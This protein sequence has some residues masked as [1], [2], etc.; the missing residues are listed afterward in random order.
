MRHVATFS[1]L[2][3]SA[4]A[5]HLPTVRTRRVCITR[6]RPAIARLGEPHGN[7]DLLRELDATKPG[8]N[9]LLRELDAT[10]PTLSYGGW[11]QDAAEV[12]DGLVRCGP[13]VASRMLAKMRRKQR[14]H[15]GDR[16]DVA[17][18]VLDEVK[19]GLAY[20]GWE[21]DVDRVERDWIGGWGTNI[22]EVR[23]TMRR[24]QQLHEGERSDVVLQVL[25]D[26]KQGL[27]YE[28]WEE[29]VRTVE[30]DWAE[31]EDTDDIQEML[32]KMRRKQGLH[33]S[34]RSDVVLQ[35]LDDVKQGLTY[36]GWEVDVGRVERDWTSGW[37]TEIQE[38]AEKMRRKQLEYVFGKLSTGSE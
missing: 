34:D 11:Q 20:D 2:L 14:L 16:S 33:E 10:K 3:A 30:R 12:E 35:V 38:V 8:N 4:T 26:V 25:D 6:A 9:D 36:D 29:D 37:D 32:A 19:Q 28:R 18:Q 13:S 21:V 1:L 31:S 22:H 7:N 23:E 17:L 27:T 15:E 24:K 5:L